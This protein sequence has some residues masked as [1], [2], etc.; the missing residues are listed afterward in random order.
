ME[1][2]RKEDGGPPERREES[3]TPSNWADWLRKFGFVGEESVSFSSSSMTCWTG[4]AAEA[5]RGDG[6]RFANGLLMFSWKG[7][8]RT[9]GKVWPGDAI[10]M[11]LMY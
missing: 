7:S 3:L 2:A 4:C 8:W 10:V 1:G 6:E 11:M 9:P 5:G